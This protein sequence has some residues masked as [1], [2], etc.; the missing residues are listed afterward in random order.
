[1]KVQAE[2]TA[3]CYQGCSLEPAA[4]SREAGPGSSLGSQPGRP[5]PNSDVQRRRRCTVHNVLGQSAWTLLLLLLLLLRVLSPP[6][7]LKSNSKS[8]RGEKRTVVPPDSQANLREKRCEGHRWTIRHS[9]AL[10]QILSRLFLEP[11]TL[12]SVQA[13]AEETH[14]PCTSG[15]FH[16]PTSQMET[17]TP[18]GPTLTE[19]RWWKQTHRVPLCVPI[20]VHSGAG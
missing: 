16:H 17:G 15:H 14:S 3:L 8:L 13:E 11:L 20:C 19:G 7:L 12:C 6:H 18:H 10:F 9:R 2:P 4:Q 5:A 1:M